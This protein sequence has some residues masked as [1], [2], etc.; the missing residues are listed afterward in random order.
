MAEE[1][2][3]YNQK[4]KEQIDTLENKFSTEREYWKGRV[5]ELSDMFNSINTIVDL[6]IELHRSLQDV[7]EYKTHIQHLVI[8]KNAI[9]RKRRLEVVNKYSNSDVRYT[10]AEKQQTMEGTI[11]ADLKHLEILEMVLN[12]YEDLAKTLHGM[13]YQIQHRIKLE[14]IATNYIT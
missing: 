10:S 14:E 6:Q 9:I 13:T 12:Y 2:K 4:I 5:Y 7:V 1:K 11:T 8:K 3:T